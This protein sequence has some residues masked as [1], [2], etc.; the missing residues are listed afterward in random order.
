MKPAEETVREPEKEVSV[1]QEQ[2]VIAKEE[3][4]GERP[5]AAEAAANNGKALPE[6]EL[7]PQPEAEISADQP[8]QGV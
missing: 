6:A 1:G 8:S 4:Q 2:D 5:I 7:T 3:S